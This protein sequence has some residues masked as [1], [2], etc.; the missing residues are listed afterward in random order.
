MA[1]AGA[2]RAAIR[3]ADKNAPVE[4][5]PMQDVISRQTSQPRAVAFLLLSFGAIA[6]FL[7]GM[8]VYGVLA[9]N[10]RRQS[11]EIGVRIA[12]GATQKHIV[13]MIVGHSLKLTLIGLAI[14]TFAGFLGTRIMASVLYGVRPLDVVPYL[15]AMLTLTLVAVFASALPALRAL[16]I[17]P[18][19]ALRAE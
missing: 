5:T 10:V 2:I 17:D 12:L 8:G 4:F 7:A 6:V 9:Y 15:A 3:E 13:S 11:H 1:L 19:L 18:S 16:R 14:G